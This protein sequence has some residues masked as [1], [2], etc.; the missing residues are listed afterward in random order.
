MGRTPHGRPP[1]G[2]H[3]PAVP[4]DPAHR[5]ELVT[6]LELGVTDQEPLV[7]LLVVRRVDGQEHRRH[8]DAAGRARG[9]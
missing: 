1:R 5:P 4:D 7:A 2:D 3:D 9:R 8:R 6:E